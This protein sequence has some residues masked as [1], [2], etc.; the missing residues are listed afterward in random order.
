M[1]ETNIPKDATRTKID[2][3][4]VF[5]DE[6]TQEP[7]VLRTIKT[8]KFNTYERR[9]ELDPY[10]TKKE[11]VTPSELGLQKTQ[12]TNIFVVKTDTSELENQM[13]YYDMLLTL[14]MEDT[15]A[16]KYKYFKKVKSGRIFLVDLESAVSS[17]VGVNSEYVKRGK[18]RKLQEN[19][20]I[21]KD[22]PVYTLNAN[23]ELELRLDSDNVW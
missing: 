22:M 13:V 19:T 5:L 11:R 7:Y 2:M 9:Y 18:V 1:S 15:R 21:S 17:L 16:N 20:L 10:D 23:G 14:E 3:T 12:S 4:K 8:F 6:K